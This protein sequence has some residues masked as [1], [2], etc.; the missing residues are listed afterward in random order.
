MRIVNTPIKELFILELEPFKDD[1]GR[2]VRL[3]CRDEL[4]AAGLKKEVVQVNSSLTR[5]KGVVRGMH[6]QYPP[7]AEI[8]M[9]RCVKGKVFDVAIDLR[10]NSPTFLHW[11]GETLSEDN[12]K[13]MCIPEG[14]AHGFQT[15]E[16]D[17]EL[18]YMHTEFYTPESQ[19][20]LHY[21][22]PKVGINWPLQVT[23]VSER[24]QN[25]VF[26][27]DTFKGIIL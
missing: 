11:Y 10:Q 22:E 12:L 4:K 14:F 17:S 15:L 20:A 9:I 1:R 23:S 24:D 6:F 25:H 26:L 21:N 27:T 5:K 19:G 7:K 18:L 8:K 13:M 3:F 16:A 2:F